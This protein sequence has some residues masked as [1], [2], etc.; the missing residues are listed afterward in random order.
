MSSKA[1]V[2]RRV[3]VP[4]IRNSKGRR[5]LMALT[6]YSGAI[7]EAVDEWVDIVLIDDAVPMEGD[8]QPGAQSFA[9]ERMVRHTGAVARA[10][11]RACVVADLPMPCCGASSEQALRSAARLLAAGAAAVRLAGGPETADT[12][13]FLV[14]CGV[15]VMGHIRRESPRAGMAPHEAAAREMER[16][17]AFGLLLDGV[18]EPAARRI[19]DVVSIPV[20]S[21]PACDGQMLETE[22]ILGLGGD[23]VQRYAEQYADVRAVAEQVARDHAGAQAYAAASGSRGFGAARSPAAI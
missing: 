5:K 17:G 19:A 8:A 20:I 1:S 10:T 6:A 2:S 21:G 18:D 23:F 13:A 11:E 12:M 9:L 4:A 16:A 14:S 15:P 7:A 22:D 3:T